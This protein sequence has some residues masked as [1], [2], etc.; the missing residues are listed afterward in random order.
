[1]TEVG[2]FK[3]IVRCY[4]PEL[5][6]RRKVEMQEA[7]AGIAELVKPIYETETQQPFDPNVEAF[8]VNYESED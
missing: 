7:I 6:A 4:M 2:K 1:M 8:L 3:G 5:Q